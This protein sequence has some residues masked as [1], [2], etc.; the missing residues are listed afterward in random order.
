MLNREPRRNID[1]VDKFEVKQSSTQITN[2]R[3]AAR[4]GRFQVDAPERDASEVLSLDLSAKNSFAPI[5]RIPTEVLSL[6]PDHLDEDKGDADRDLITL[7][8]VSRGWRSTFV[9]RSSLWTWLD[10]MDVEKTCTYIQR[11]GFFPLEIFLEKDKDGGYLDDAFGLVIPHIHRIKSLTIHTDVLPAAIRYFSCRVP[12][13]E[14]L[15]IRLTCTPA[16]IF[17]D[18]LFGPD[19]S[20]L[21]ELS[22]SGVVARLPWKNLANITS[23]DLKARRPGRNIVSRL[24]DFFE[25][26]PLLHTIKLRDTIPKSSGAPSGRVVSL[27]R[28]SLLSIHANPVHSLLL[29]HLCIPTGALVNLR[30]EFGSDKSPFRD[31]LPETIGNL[32]N[33]SHITTINLRF[34]EVG[35][36]VR[37]E[38]PSGGLRIRGHWRSRII[39]AYDM[40]HRILLSFDPS[41]LL[42][43]KRLA[44]WGYEHTRPPEVEN[45]PIPQTLFSMNN[46]RTLVLAEC[47]NFPFILALSPKKN[48]SKLVLCPGLEELVLYVEERYPLYIKSLTFMAKARASRDAKLSLITIVSPDELAPGKEG[49]EL[50]EYV[51]RVEYRVDNPPP[52]W[53]TIPDDDN[54]SE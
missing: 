51:E 6:I 1:S 12:R 23:F 18:T 42:T 19:L 22:L 8:H 29:D 40:D 14:K 7:T 13:L 35:K 28:L 41:V 21:R 36:F 27:P 54:K 5:N 31:Y 10:C 38:G 45:C 4:I 48:A 50:R 15:D 24:L 3:T 25:N 34:G 9:S 53:D 47:C 2:M 20:S 49:F 17:D 46:L 52:S 26:A 44:V 33:L 43:T 39:P 11:S 32:R 30:F 16:P 37:M